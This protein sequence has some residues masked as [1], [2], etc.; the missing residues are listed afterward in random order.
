[1]RWEVHP[2]GDAGE[3][4]GGILISFEDVTGLRKMENQLLYSQKMETIGQLSAGVAHEFRNALNIILLQLESARSEAVPESSISRS[5]DSMYSAARRAEN[6]TEN[7]LA[8]SRKRTA[9]PEPIDTEPFL[10]DFAQ[11]VRPLIGEKVRFRVVANV[12]LPRICFDPMQLEQVLINLI[13]NALDVMAEGGVLTVEA[14][15]WNGHMFCPSPPADPK[16]VF[17]VSDTGPGIDPSIL[18]HI[19][20]PFYTTKE[21]GRGTGL[22]L[23]ISKTILTEGGGSIEVHSVQ[24]KGTRFDLLLPVCEEPN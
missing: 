21:E 2:W 17:S 8:F 1:L 9:R 23:S 20:E 15:L 3:T 10:R 14:N 4:T 5:L 16:V 6:V 24:G 7:L 18:P 12:G 22:G 13:S 19:F 11:I